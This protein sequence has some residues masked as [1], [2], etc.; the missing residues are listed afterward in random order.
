MSAPYKDAM[1]GGPTVAA[2]VEIPLTDG[3]RRRGA[4]KRTAVLSRAVQIASTNGLEGLTIGRLAADLKISK[5]NIT[6][7]FGDKEA[8]QIAT[9]D[10]AVTAFASRVVKP[11]M[12]EASP[13]KRLRALCEGWFS[14]VEDRVLPGGCMLYASSNEYRA[15]PGPIRDRVNHHRHAWNDALT[16]A[17]RD[18]QTAGEI[19]PDLDVPQL[20]FE[21]TAYQAGANMAALLGDRGAF[22]RARRATLERIGAAATTLPVSEQRKRR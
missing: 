8:L 2:R 5:G 3:R 16:A 13:I 19:R 1:S 12:A 17:V 10:A 7:L 14:Y 9:L 4:R 18:A 11:S 22:L 15:R 21:L 20:V 6:V